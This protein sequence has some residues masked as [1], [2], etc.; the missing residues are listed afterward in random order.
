MPQLTMPREGF[1]P[2]LIAALSAVFGVVAAVIL[3]AIR[4]FVADYTK[5]CKLRRLIYRELTFNYERL[6]YLQK[7]QN[8]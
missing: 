7:Q 5:R 8:E 4:P 2:W 1:P 6:Y 3:D